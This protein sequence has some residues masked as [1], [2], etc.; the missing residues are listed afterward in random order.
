LERKKKTKE[1]FDVDDDDM[2]NDIEGKKLQREIEG[3]QIGGQI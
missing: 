2:N 1:W 3:I